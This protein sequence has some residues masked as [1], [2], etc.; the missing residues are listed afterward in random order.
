VVEVPSCP[1]TKDA[2]RRADRSRA[3]YL[4]HLVELGYHPC[5]T[6]Q[7]MIDQAAADHGGATEPE[8]GDA[9]DIELDEL[10]EDDI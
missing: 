6:E 3:A 5:E 10:D 2:W 7:L 4:E 9:P 8:P 1:R